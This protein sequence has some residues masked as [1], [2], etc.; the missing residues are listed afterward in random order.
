MPAGHSARQRRAAEPVQ[1]DRQA[2]DASCQ[3]GER[4]QAG[5][6]TACACHRA[7]PV[8]PIISEAVAVPVQVNE[9]TPISDRNLVGLV[10]VTLTE[11]ERGPSGATA[12]WS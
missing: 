12:Y 9:S 5:S 11:I 3:Q 1:H 6:D 2:H 8:T 7:A 10:T 4:G